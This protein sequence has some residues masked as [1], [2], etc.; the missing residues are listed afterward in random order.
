MTFEHSVQ[1]SLAQSIAHEL[2]FLM[3][4]AEGLPET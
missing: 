3:F 4:I 2:S 1:H